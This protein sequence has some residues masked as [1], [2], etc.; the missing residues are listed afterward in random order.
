MAAS[1]S[2]RVVDVSRQARSSYGEVTPASGED[3]LTVGAERHGSDTVLMHEGLSDRLAG[4]GVPQSRRRVSAPGEHRLAVGA[5][6]HGIYHV[7]VR[8]GGADEPAGG[9]IPEPRRVIG[10]AGEDGLAVGA[11][12]HV[13]DLETMD[14]G[15]TERSPG[16]DV[17]QPPSC[18]NSLWRTVLP[19]G[20]KATRVIL[21]L[22]EKTALSPGVCRAQAERLARAACC[23]L[24]S[25][26]ATAERQLSTNS[27]SPSPVR[28]FS[29][30]ASPRSKRNIARWRFDSSS[31]FCRLSA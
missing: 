10:A 20:L 13:F 16:G 9:G 24:G 26:A 8:E 6:R 27:S 15:R 4:G 25:L 5:E 31:D 23:H 2:R 22:C 14:E 29:N 21:S 11:E 30:A 7:L 3:G 19:S 17:P 18:R 28:P 12:R 1:H